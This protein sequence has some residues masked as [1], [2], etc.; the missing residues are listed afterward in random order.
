MSDTSPM[1]EFDDPP[2]DTSFPDPWTPA[3]D[4]LAD[5]LV[6]ARTALR[7]QRRIEKIIAA[8]ITVGLAALIIAAESGMIALVIIQ[9]SLLATVLY[10]AFR[11]RPRLRMLQES[12]A[13]LDVIDP[14]CPGCG[15]SLRHLTRRRCPECGRGV[16]RILPE[17]IEYVLQGGRVS[18]TRG[19][20][21]SDLGW[22]ALLIMLLA[23][24]VIG[25]LTS[26]AIGFQACAVPLMIFTL[27]LVVRGVRNVRQVSRQ[28]PCD[29]CRHPVSL[30][31]DKTCSQCGADV[32]ANHVYV[33]PGM[34]GTGDP[35]L[36][37][38]W[39]HL[40]GAT[41]ICSALVIIPAIK[42][43]DALGSPLFDFG[44]W[45]LPP[46]M[47]I[48][49]IILLIADARR[50]SPTRVNVFDTS[51]YPLCHHCLGSLN[52]QPANGYCVHCGKAYRGIELAGGRR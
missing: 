20:V 51:V 43:N 11:T 24:T 31:G 9:A 5:A 19:S 6:A 42:S 21:E 52:R 35:R 22:V 30:D 44:Q 34:A 1:L 7:K 40:I 15:Y 2:D 18:I 13:K 39:C 49:A 32:L 29:R 36:C 4:E 45:L 8:L 10:H 50:R 12:Q 28:V 47:L 17:P 26:P 48:V 3:A 16:L 41:R 33:R 25:K 23:A 37:R 27:F 38:P 14:Q 46:V